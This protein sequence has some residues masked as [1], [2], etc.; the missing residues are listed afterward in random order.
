MTGQEFITLIKDGAVKAQKQYGICASLTMAQAILESGWGQHAPGNNLF[1]IKWTTRCGYDSKMLATKEFINGKWIAM[2][3]PFR[4]Y[5]S[6]ADSVYD[7]AMFLVQNS[8]YKSL[9]GVKYYKTA[10]KLIQQLGYATAPNY[11]EQLIQIIEENQLY[12][13]DKIEEVKKMKNLI[14][15]SGDGDTEAAKL[16]SLSL[17]APMIAKAAAG[18]DVINAAENI[19]VVGGSWKPNNK[20]KLISGTDRIGTVKATIAYLGR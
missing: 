16:L 1:G 2:E 18:D 8:R 6:L 4:A 5:N 11:T 10:C 9:L 17:K 20:A 13:F 19:I 14:I 7:H 3:A 12:K 15:Y